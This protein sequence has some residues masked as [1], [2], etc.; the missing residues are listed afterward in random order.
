MYTQSLRRA[1]VLRHLSVW[2]LALLAGGCATV[3]HQRILDDQGD[4]ADR[5]IRYY[6]TSPYLIAYSDGK[7]GMVTEVR[8][9][10]DPKKKMS[11]SP[12][13]TLADVG[14]T[15]TF[16]R[17]VLTEST[18]TG[19]ATA[20][21]TAILKAVEAFGPAL[22]GLLN[23]A[24]KQQEHS[25]PAPYVYK[26]VVR[27]GDVHFVGGRGDEDVKITLLPQKKED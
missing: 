21:P 10:P 13:T 12:R 27:G 19:D 24:Q 16:D 15:L 8:Y 1:C 23:E 4:D 5:G 17:G 22:L 26:I 2:L 18:E 7:G 9:L 11:A 14:A 3:T 6:G 25:L 20:V